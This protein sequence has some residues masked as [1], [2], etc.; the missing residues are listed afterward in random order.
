MQRQ[1]CY[2]QRQRAK[3]MKEKRIVSKSQVI[4]T[5]SQEELRLKNNACENIKKRSFDKDI[6]RIAQ[7]MN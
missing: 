4:Y 3:T 6:R 1:R 5:R 7:K 2:Y